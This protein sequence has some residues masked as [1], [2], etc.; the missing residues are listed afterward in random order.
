MRKQVL[1]ECTAPQK[2]N[3][4]DSESA[5]RCP[6]GELLIGLALAAVRRRRRMEMR[7]GVR[8]MN[9]EE[10]LTLNVEIKGGMGLCVEREEDF[11]ST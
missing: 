8:M 4:K 1:L 2:S 9:I 7:V 3:G 10:I 6:S 11:I 5:M